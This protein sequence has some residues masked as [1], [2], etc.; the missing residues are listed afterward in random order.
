MPPFLSF[1]GKNFSLGLDFVVDWAY[2]YNCR[3]VFRCE[4]SEKGSISS[5]M[6]DIEIKKSFRD[7]IHFP[8]ILKIDF[9]K[10]VPFRQQLAVMCTILIISC[11]LFTVVYLQQLLSGK[12]AVAEEAVTSEESSE[13]SAVSSESEPEP[14]QVQSSEVSEEESSEASGIAENTGD[15]EMLGE[16][17]SITKSYGELHEG[18]L[19]LVNK[20][21]SCRYD[22]ENVEPIA[23]MISDTYVLFDNTVSLD[24]SVVESLNAMMDD[25]AAVQGETDIMIACG[26][27]SYETQVELYNEEIDEVGYDD[28][29]QWVAP[30]GYSEHQTGLVIDLDLNAEGING[31]N[32]DGSGE[33]SWI[34]DHCSEY[35]FIVRYIDGK[36]DI[37]GFSAEPWHLR[38]V[39]L[40]HSLYMT[41][42]GL[43]LEEYIDLL[44]QHDASKPLL[45]EKDE[46]HRW[47]VYYVSAEDD[48]EISIPVPE[49]LEYDLSGDNYSGFIVTVKL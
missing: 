32:F 21:Y 25:F 35:G 17:T 41:Q 5:N 42:N 10:P 15:A 2:Y 13:I 34:T 39:G 26:Y 38:Y 31:I 33:Y 28:A 23:S 14:S 36:K 16:M 37:T 46:E 20:D 18:K 43:V 4:K 24:T 6:K 22:G 19:I 3:V 7:R 40:P 30:P 27:R 8:E 47:C 9:E 44:H 29:G 12:V 11:L 48:E 45:I 49:E 1:Y